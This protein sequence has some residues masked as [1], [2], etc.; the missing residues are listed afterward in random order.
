MIPIDLF[1]KA[2]PADFDRVNTIVKRNNTS[3]MNKA[4]IYYDR[5]IR[6]AKFEIGDT[7]LIYNPKP[8]HTK[9]QRKWDGPY[10][11]KA[12]NNVDYI[13]ESTHTKELKQNMYTKIDLKN[14]M[15]RLI[16]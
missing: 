9:L 8:N 12:R 16:K 7:V 2:L 4:K 5:K 3:R 10:R 11:V 1:Y 14:G 6:E 13:V 15:V